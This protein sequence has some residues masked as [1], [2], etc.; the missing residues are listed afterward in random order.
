[1]IRHFILATLF[2]ANVSPVFAQ[3]PAK[4]DFKRDV[5]PILNQSCI[6]C[7]GPTQQMNGFRLDRR[8][9]ALRGGTI[10]KPVLPGDSARSE[11][12][13]R[14]VS[15]RFGP[16]MPPT[17]ALPAAQIDIIKRWI[18]EGAVW[19][20][21]ASGETP[22][23][24]PDPKATAIMNA[25]RDGDRA[26]F[27][28]LVTDSADGI[29]KKGPNGAT[30]LMYA[31]LYGDAD[32]VRL[33][34]EKSADPNA[35]NDRGATALIW[36]ADNAEKTR[37]LL[38]RG[39]DVN[40]RSEDGRTAL[41]VAAGLFGSNSVVKQ[42]LDKGADPK[43]TGLSLFGPWNPLIAA[44]RTGNEAVMRMLIER[45]ADPKSADFPGIVFAA[46]SECSPCLEL[47]AGKA[48]PMAK[49]IAATLL[50]PPLGT[51][52]YLPL[53]LG[54]GVD[55]NARD[56]EGHTLL[57]MASASDR[58]PDT[59]VKS[60]IDKGADINAKG[61][62]GETALDLAKQRGNTPVVDLLVKA[63]V[64]ESLAPVPAGRAKPS[65]SAREAVERV[66]PLLQK[67]DA[68]FLSKSGCV[69]CHNNTLA[70]MT[71]SAARKSGIA[72]N[73]QT[74]QKQLKIIAST[75]E[76]WRERLLQGIG[77][78]GDSDTVSYILMGMAAEKYPAD[79]TTDAM[80]KFVKDQQWPDGHWQILAHRPP[81]ESSDV[82]V[83][84]ASMR[85][86]QLYAP[87][88]L[89]ADYDKAV[90]KTVEW[91]KKAQPASTEESAFQ[92]MGLRW[93]GVSAGDS[94][95]QKAVR[96][97]TA[98]QRADGGWSQIPTL[99]SDAYATGQALV[100]LKEAGVAATDAIYKKG[101][102]YLLNSQ[103]EDGS[104]HVRSRAVPLQP[105]FDSGFPHER[106]QWISA[107]GSNWAAL[108]LIGVSY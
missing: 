60:L 93:G 85:A 67:S 81:I 101:V 100:A 2:L 77:I 103:L 69:S 46:R 25:L 98:Q 88:S 90:Q 27:G 24:P 83:T 108:A 40:A 45:G 42:L 80:A 31:V 41:M 82:Q 70:A 92:I 50:V 12:Y 29:N 106:D 68:A 74:A 66:L 99:T 56:P 94:S 36:A 21:D 91:L 76:A 55:V 75:V 33:L 62:R 49:N 53:M 95:V 18:E 4:V 51:T 3:S 23:A 9:D 39:A 86:L 59:L 48:E 13:V 17:G 22:S 6:G 30:P 61:P 71:V 5:Q 16:K 47:L 7:H 38:A 72:V 35:R 28:K 79:A 96:N 1:M 34:L 87:K 63:G 14:L 15:E 105:L 19:S 32:S 26:S 107:A 102:Q 78:P 43:V 104:W 73:E 84:A 65:S 10:S 11:M 97:L 52:Q 44:A 54:R 64:K 58:I 8:S 89:R 37:L 57:M 20:D